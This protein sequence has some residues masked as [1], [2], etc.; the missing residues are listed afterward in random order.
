MDYGQDPNNDESI[1]GS[2]SDPEGE[3]FE[4]NLKIFNI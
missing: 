4:V 1:S 2:D 3:L